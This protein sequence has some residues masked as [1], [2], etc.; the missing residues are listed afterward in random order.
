[1]AFLREKNNLFL[2]VV[3]SDT[4]VST[5]LA[6]SSPVDSRTAGSSFR[7]S[8]VPPLASTNCVISGLEDFVTTSLIAVSLM[9]FDRDAS[10]ACTGFASSVG[11]ET[12]LLSTA[13]SFFIL[14]G[15]ELTFSTFN[16]LVV[17]GEL[18]NCNINKK[19]S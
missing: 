7:V 2:G 5:T 19:S 6:R 18:G 10:Q 15:T 1:M 17:L 11:L 16:S 13:A 4:T 14:V 8:R 12:K 3:S 9:I